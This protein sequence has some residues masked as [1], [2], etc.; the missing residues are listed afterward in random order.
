[1]EFKN[2]NRPDN[3]LTC[4]PGLNTVHNSLMVTGDAHSVHSS[5]KIKWKLPFTLA[6]DLKKKSWGRWHS[7][8][9]INTIRHAKTNKTP[10]WFDCLPMQVFRDWSLYIWCRISPQKRICSNKQVPSTSYTGI[11]QVIGIVSLLSHSWYFSCLLT[12]WQWLKKKKKKKE[13]YF[14]KWQMHTRIQRT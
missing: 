7:E 3:K 2:E 9:I 13:V 8:Y 4:T 12:I 14:K 11:W 5:W 1:M 10:D 6:A